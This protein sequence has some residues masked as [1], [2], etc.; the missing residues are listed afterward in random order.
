MNSLEDSYRKILDDLPDRDERELLDLLK[1]GAEINRL[2][3][4]ERRVFQ[5]AL[6]KKTWRQNP[7]LL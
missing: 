6:E 1:R 5:E 7:G 3:A 4:E 2:L